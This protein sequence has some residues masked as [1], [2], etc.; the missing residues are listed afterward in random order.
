M[1]ILTFTITKKKEFSIRRQNDSPRCI[2]LQ[3]SPICSNRESTA[4]ILQDQVSMI[5]IKPSMANTVI[6]P[7]VT[8]HVSKNFP[9]SPR[10]KRSF[11]RSSRESPSADSEKF[12]KTSGLDHLKKNLQMEGASKGASDLIINSWCKSSFKHYKLAWGKWVSRCSR[13]EM[14]PTRCDIS[15]VLNFLAELFDE[16][17]Q[18]NKI[19]LHRSTLLVFHNPTQV[20]KIVDHQRVCNLLS[21]VFIQIP[22]Q[23]KNTFISHVELVLK[24]GD[25]QRFCDLLSG[26]FI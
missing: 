2:N 18:Y 4:E 16:D 7:R 13:Q 11:E 23:P 8:W 26:V 17:W 1:T 9:I 15:Y 14:C 20:I 24:I 22:P 5:L 10:N 21:G 19:G 25:H 12:F 6:F 3:I